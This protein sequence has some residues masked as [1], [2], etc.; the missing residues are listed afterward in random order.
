VVP[1]SQHAPPSGAS[2]PACAERPPHCCCQVRACSGQRRGWEGGPEVCIGAVVDAC[3]GMAR[4]GAATWLQPWRPRRA[5]C[6]CKN[7]TCML[8]APLLLCARDVT[9]LGAFGLQKMHT[10]RS[11][12][13][14]EGPQPPAASTSLQMPSP[15]PHPGQASTPPA[16]GSDLIAKARGRAAGGARAAAS[17][18]RLET[19]RPGAQ[20]CAASRAGH[21]ARLVTICGGW[22]GAGT[23]FVVIAAFDRIGQGRSGGGCSGA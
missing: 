1:A 12:R 17:G 9:G 23:M 3:C 7:A 4:V 5:V 10:A 20:T 14:R 6:R 13:R 19:R 11:C 8:A 18:R 21:L 2:A 16:A 22:G 15:P